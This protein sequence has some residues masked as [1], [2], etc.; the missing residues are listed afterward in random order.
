VA[1][2]TTACPNNYY[3]PLIWV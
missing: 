2:D 1:N 3:V